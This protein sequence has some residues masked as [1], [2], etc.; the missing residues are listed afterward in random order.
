MDWASYRM[1][2]S[3][4]ITPWS[5]ESLGVHAVI[6]QGASF[7]GASSQAWPVANVAYFYP[8]TLF[9]FAIVYQ[10]L[11]W[12]G[13]TAGGLIDVGIYDRAGNRILSAGSTGM[14]ATINTVQELNVTDTRIPP[15]EYWLAG[16]CNSTG[17]TVFRNQANDELVFP[18]API[19][20]LTGLTNATLP[21]TAAPVP[22]T[23]N[24]PSLIAIG[25]QLRSVF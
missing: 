22:T 1:P 3:P 20:E 25:A 21:A 18:V 10:F 4:I 24:T 23:V 17:V 5:H 13:A 8:F 11:F 12:V 16:A 14:S 6:Q 7:D 15:G 9:D 2:P 19:Y